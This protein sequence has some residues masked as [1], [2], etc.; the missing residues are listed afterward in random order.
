[1]TETLE[2]KKEIIQVTWDMK[3]KTTRLRE[4]R[5]LAEAEQELNMAGRIIDKEA[6]LT[7]SLKR[8]KS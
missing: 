6:Y 2:G 8:F 3:D 1:M 5:A 7:N 4:E